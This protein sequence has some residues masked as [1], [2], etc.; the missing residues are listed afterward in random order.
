[1]NYN[2]DVEVLSL[3][4]PNLEFVEMLFTVSLSTL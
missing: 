1:M 2:L 4:L 3:I